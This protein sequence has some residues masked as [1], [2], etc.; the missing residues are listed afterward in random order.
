LLSTPTIAAEPS[1]PSEAL[2]LPPVGRSGRSPIPTDALVERMA[3][4]KWTAPKA[5]DTVKAANGPERKW[6]AVPFR[7]GAVAHRALGGGY[8][9]FPVES[10]AERVVILEASSHTMAYAN[11]EPRRDIYQTGYVR[12]PILLRKERTNCSSTSLAG[13][14]P[15]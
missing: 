15:N 6:E 5:G 3:A 9:F 10:D 7:D 8:A 11:G 1:L 13:C 2:V 14:G 12:V 4:G